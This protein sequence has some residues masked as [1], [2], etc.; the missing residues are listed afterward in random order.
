MAKYTLIIEDQ[1]GNRGEAIVNGYSDRPRLVSWVMYPFNGTPVEGVALPKSL[2]QARIS[3]KNQF[4]PPA[5]PRDGGSE[6][7]WATFR[8]SGCFTPRQ[9]RRARL[10]LDCCPNSVPPTT[11]GPAII[12]YLH[13]PFRLGQTRYISNGVCW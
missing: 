2:N 10:G 9:D 7:S 5:V 8:C 1:S 6:N 3:F 12:R 4:G 11:R 13:Q